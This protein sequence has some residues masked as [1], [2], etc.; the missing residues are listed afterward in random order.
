MAPDIKSYMSDTVLLETRDGIA[1]LTLNRP[2][3]L[4]ALNLDMARALADI[5]Q[6]VEASAQARCVI[7]RGAGGN[8]LAG[9]DVLSMRDGLE[10]GDS[11][12]VDGIITHLH[13]A[14][15]IMQRMSKPVIAGVEGAVAGGGVSLL[16]ACD[17]ALAADNSKFNLA[18]SLI[19]ANPDGGATWHLP[20][21]A[22]LK[23]AM[24]LCLLSEQFNATDALRMGLVNRVVAAGN[25]EKETR[26][27]ARRL[28]DGPLDAYARIKQ[29]LNDAATNS[30]SQ[31]LS[32][33]QNAFVEGLR[34]R[35]FSEGVRAFCEKRK[36]K[37]N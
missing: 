37:F 32:A 35:D 5:C 22:G 8:F 25:L 30:L 29:L 31:Q 14:V 12:I 11:S 13:L 26:A 17:L 9:G 6:E 18:Y 28:A 7:V 19:G 24:E 10:S 15:E 33:E 3:S 21:L 34:S 4:N 23:K 20:R 2:K 16:L 36:P 27:W 1:T